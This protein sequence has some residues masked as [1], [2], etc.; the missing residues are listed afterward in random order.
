MKAREN[1]TPVTKITVSEKELRE[2]LS[3]GRG[4]AIQIGEESGARIRIG[5]RILY[6]VDKVIEYIDSL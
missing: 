5:G 6:R 4:L 3:I 2:M 1:N